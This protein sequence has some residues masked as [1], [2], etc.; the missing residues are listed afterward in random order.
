MATIPPPPI[1]GPIAGPPVKIAPTGKARVWIYT[2]DANA[3]AW[4]GPDSL[5]VYWNNLPF[6]YYYNP[7]NAT[8]PAVWVVVDR[9][10]AS[11]NT[12][13]NVLEYPNWV[14][15]SDKTTPG[16][17]TGDSP[18]PQPPP[19]PNPSTDCPPGYIFVPWSIVSQPFD[20]LDEDP[21]G[22]VTSQQQGLCVPIGPAY[23]VLPSCPPGT[24][25]DATAEKCVPDTVIPPPPP[26]C[27][28][29]EYWD[30]TTETCKPVPKRPIC[31]PG[32]YWDP[33]TETCRAIPP[34]PPP[35]PQCPPGTVW[36]PDTRKCI[37]I[38]NPFQP[39]IPD[40]GNPGDELTNGLNC[41]SENLLVIQQLLQQQLQLAGQPTGTPDPVTCAQLTR[42]VNSI[43]ALL[44]AIAL[45]IHDISGGAPVDLSG[46][47]TALEHLYTA[48]QT[49]PPVWNAIAAAIG[50]KLD[51]IA[52]AVSSVG[53]PDLKPLV[54]AVNKL[55]TTLDVPMPVYQ[56]L[57]SEGWI[58]DE[59][60]SL[61]GQG[62]YG[63][64]VILTFKDY[65]TRGIAWI[66]SEVESP[67]G[68]KFAPAF[69]AE[70]GIA[71]FLAGLT[72]LA[73]N[74]ASVPFYPVI[75]GGVDGVAISLVPTAP[76]DVGDVHVDESLI[77]TKTLAPIL[78]LNSIMLIA[79][80][81]GW[82]T[83]EQLKEYVDVAGEVLGLKEISE[84]TIGSRMRNGPARVADMQAKKLY[85][86]ELP[87]YST[88]AGWVA[89]GLLSQNWLNNNG[90]L[91]G[92]PK[93]LEPIA[94]LA[95]Y[96]G[97]N[98]RQLLRLIETDIFS[99]QDIQDELTF[100]GMRPASQS[101]MLTAAPY[102]ATASE[103]SSLRS[104]IESAYVAGL[105]SDQ[106]LQSQVLAIEQNTDLA[107]LVLARGRLQKLIA[108]TKAL[109]TE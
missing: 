60:L 57:A 16:V 18:Q 53:S 43:N 87:G 88:L 90:A 40:V 5:D 106:D 82:N 23:S 80:Y 30:I 50:G 15:V 38:P 10:D 22:T 65:L 27:P 21:I 24:H 17:A 19:P 55:F 101:R 3:G 46:V 39:C 64:G 96:R 54:D 29:G 104:T 85:R 93:V 70:D 66:I 28:P 100:S 89:Q 69:K 14:V 83:S 31:P 102:L 94:Q 107:G 51:N 36:D 26:N 97:L 74:A 98:P 52:T 72:N 95:S 2:Y 86:Q 68:P 45:G 6:G 108:E 61:L 109:E 1:T 48:L 37:P 7:T 13:P 59:T 34:P 35:P 56:Q 44:R 63:P 25:W 78:V 58:S 33:V 71:K 62:E 91:T 32:T 75:K 77:Y 20:Q 105:L 41:I 103:R 11:G 49:Y 79:G 67:A 4:T 84:L 12:Q 42:L 73:L 76:V 8:P 81:L 92:I 47:V 99:P 9:T